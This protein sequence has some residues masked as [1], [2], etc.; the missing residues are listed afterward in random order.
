[1][2][3]IVHDS[4]AAGRKGR[5]TP[6]L[7]QL[8]TCIVDGNRMRNLTRCSDANAWSNGMLCFA[9]NAPYRARLLRGVENAV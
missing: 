2:R 1:M 7:T 8:A 3:Y 5:Y 6:R 9:M 4:L